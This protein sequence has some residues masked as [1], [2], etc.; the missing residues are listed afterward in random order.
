MKKLSLILG[1]FVIMLF[2][3][4]ASAD[5]LSARVNIALDDGTVMIYAGTKKGVNIGDEFDVMRSGV[6]AGHMKVVRVKDL[7]AYCE[8][9]EGAVQ[10]MDTVTRV[11]IGT[12][13]DA[14]AIAAAVQANAQATPVTAAPAGGGEPAATKTTQTTAVAGSET[15]TA[16]TGGADSVTES[17]AS[18]TSKRRETAKIEGET[19][20]DGT[21]TTAEPATGAKETKTGGK[22]NKGDKGKTGATE[23][24]KSGP[25]PLGIPQPAAFGLTG[26]ITIPSGNVNPA[27]KFSALLAYANSS[28]KTNGFTNTGFGINYGVSGDMEFSYMYLSNSNKNSLNTSSSKQK[29]NTSVMSFKYQLPFTT[30]PS[31]IKQVKD[32][33]I[34]VG[35]QIFNR[36]TNSDSSA[37]STSSNTKATRIYAVG[38]SKIMKGFGHLGIYDQTGDMVAGTDNKGLGFM[39]GY[40]Y[41]LARGA[42]SPLEQMTLFLEL[43]SKSLY[44]NTYKTLSLGLRYGFSS[45]QIG[46]SMVD[47]TS[48]QALVMSG[49]YNF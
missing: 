4:A 1:I 20:P 42:K 21:A 2:T 26:L 7:F 35:A 12:P 32:V 27:N 48:T 49:G 16:A 3:A 43:D 29:G 15:S 45:G 22:D 10:E 19:K 6:R 46:L 24:K 41:P 31:F 13:A 17:G 28:D 30:P 25:T 9:T 40:E 23:V 11:K 38:T 5:D 47:I 34:G 8:M 37:G 33:R 18:R 39:G 44:L 14:A 36:K